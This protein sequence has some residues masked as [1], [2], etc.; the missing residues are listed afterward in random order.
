M[1]AKTL[2]GIFETTRKHDLPDLTIGLAV[3]RHENPGH[4]TDDTDRPIRE[5]IGRHYDALVKAYKDGP[6]AF[7]DAVASCE[8]ADESK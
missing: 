5:F 1:N 3:Y 8:A 2:Y 6:V 4:V 7:E